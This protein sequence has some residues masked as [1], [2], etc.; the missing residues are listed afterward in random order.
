M[1][2]ATPRG[3]AAAAAV[4]GAPKRQRKAAGAPTH[5]AIIQCCKKHEAS[6][7][8]KQEVLEQSLSHIPQSEMLGALNQL[9]TSGK[10]VACPGHDKKLVFRLQSDEQAAKFQGLSAE[11]RLIYQEI[12]KSEGSGV[13]NKDLRIRTGMQPQPLTQVLKT[14]ETR[15]LIKPVKSVNAKNKKLYILFDVEASKEVISSRYSPRLQ[16][17]THS[18]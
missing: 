2:A 8:V 16:T 4:A 11:D 17:G 9:M 3:P 14:L 1:S 13:S 10:V 12:E 15:R 5:D 6:G 7:G 18:L